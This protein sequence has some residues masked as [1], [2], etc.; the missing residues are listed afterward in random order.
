[1]LKVPF[2]GSRPNIYEP[3]GIAIFGD[4]QTAQNTAAANR[5]EGNGWLVQL[6]MVTGQRYIFNHSL[7]FGVS[8]NSSA[9]AL[10]R[11][12]EVVNC[13]AQE[14][15][16]LLGAND[17]A[18]KLPAQ[19]TI[20]NVTAIVAA[21]TAVGKKVTIIS[22]LPRRDASFVAAGF[23]A[24]EI[25]TAKDN[26]EIVNAAL[27]QLASPVVRY[28]DAYSLWVDPV[29]RQAKVG[30]TLDD[31]HQNAAGANLIMRTL[32]DIFTPIYGV[33]EFRLDPNN[34]FVNTN[35][36]GSGGSLSG[37]TGSLAANH[38]S[39]GSAP[40][41]TAGRVFSKTSR[42]GQRMDFDFPAGGSATDNFRCI[43][44]LT[45]SGETGKYAYYE[46]ELDIL[47]AG[48][49]S[50]I[51]RTLSAELQTSVGSLSIGNDRAGTSDP[52]GLDLMLEFM[53]AKGRTLLL[54]TPAMAI[55][56]ATYV[57]GRFNIEANTTGGP[58]AGSIE[59]LNEQLVIY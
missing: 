13:S 9:Q 12:S 2:K 40:T 59:L 36:A 24:S 14:V 34:R 32:Y 43:Q 38:L 42:G 48:I 11:V 28:A 35:F 20:D 31:L 39:L 47:N 4:S 37:C 10:A 5:F 17:R 46:V 22:H 55:P 30:L 57:E 8:G 52:M 33:R 51:W 21:I 6:N 18:G 1:M 44:R 56:A 15:I 7:N 19:T 53:R 23:T 25:V 50:G 26:T 45:S 16:V 29:D 49:G 54:R 58:L 27:K 41:G 3:V